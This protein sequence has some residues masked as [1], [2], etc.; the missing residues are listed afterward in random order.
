MIF[1]MS[2]DNYLQHLFLVVKIGSSGKTGTDPNPTQKN[3]SFF[4]VI[5]LALYFLF[6][7]VTYLTHPPIKFNHI[8]QLVIASLFDWLDFWTSNII[9]KQ[10]IFYSA[11]FLSYIPCINQQT[12]TIQTLIQYNASVH[13]TLYLFIFFFRSSSLNR[14]R[15]WFDTISKQDQKVLQWD[16]RSH[17]WALAV[18]VDLGWETD[19]RNTP[20]VVGSPDGPVS[21]KPW[22]PH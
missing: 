9:L 14:K 4:F 15:V 18:V 20:A 13:P 11:H 3:F 2:W 10:S 17:V 21:P 1:S 5:F 16:F 6:C 12:I 8:V 22:T 7:N 19:H